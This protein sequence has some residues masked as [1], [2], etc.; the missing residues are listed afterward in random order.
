MHVINSDDSNHSYLIMM[1]NK[2]C[3][4]EVGG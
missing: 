1:P 3:K 2:L 4:Q